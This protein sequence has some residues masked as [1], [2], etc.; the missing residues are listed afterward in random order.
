MFFSVHQKRE[1][2]EPNSMDIY[3]ADPGNGILVLPMP[4]IKEAQADA[5]DWT[6]VTSAKQRR[7]LQNR[8]NQRAR[9]Q[10]VTFP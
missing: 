9:S 3:S 8:L 5:E 10:Y 4:Q 2:L 1:D 6:G 7:K